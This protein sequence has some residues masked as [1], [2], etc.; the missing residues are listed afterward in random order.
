[1]CAVNVIKQK[2]MKGAETQT[3]WPP[4]RYQVNPRNMGDLTGFYHHK[5]S[6]QEAQ[7]PW[8][9][10]SASTTAASL[11]SVDSVQFLIAI[12]VLYQWAVNFWI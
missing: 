8:L 2:Q 9:Q 4:L 5:Q 11:R 10:S 3:T 1:M 6:H 12:S 7:A